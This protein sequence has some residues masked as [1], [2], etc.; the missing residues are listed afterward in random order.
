MLVT[1]VRKLKWKC[2]TAVH[3]ATAFC[4]RI[5]VRPLWG[6]QFGLRTQHT[7][8]TPLTHEQKLVAHRQELV[9]AHRQKLV[10]AHRRKL[11][12]AHRQKLVLPHR[13]K[14]VLAHRQ[15]LVLARASHSG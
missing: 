15:K 10:L 7:L 6:H 4:D 13:Q 12:L 3:T 8:P 2:P 9:L 1:S 14:L 5:E 11:V